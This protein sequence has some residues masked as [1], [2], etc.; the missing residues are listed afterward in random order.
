[1]SFVLGRAAGVDAGPSGRLGSYRARDG[2]EGAPLHLDLD[3]PHAVSIVGKRG[4]GK[5]YTLGVI[6]ESLARADGV[7]P[8]SIR[9]ARSRR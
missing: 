3:G 5:S 8:V 9:W 7:A 4:Y 2:S 6:A 1:M